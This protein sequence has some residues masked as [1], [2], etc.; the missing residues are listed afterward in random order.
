MRC[1]NILSCDQ[2]EKSSTQ[3]GWDTRLL[4]SLYS[5]VQ[6][7]SHA[8]ISLMSLLDIGSSAGLLYL[9]HYFMSFVCAH[10]KD[11]SC[12][13][14][15]IFS[16]KTLGWYLLEHKKVIY[17]TLRNDLHIQAQSVRTD[18]SIGKS[19]IIF[20]LSLTSSIEHSYQPS[21]Q[22]QVSESIEN[23]SA[24]SLCVCQLN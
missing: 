14:I 21:S 6:T 23:V 5:Q 9:F 10:C 18:M 11:I 15:F 13:S 17:F 20:F 24:A 19:F 8:F 2:H 16:Y 12:K 22:A 3:A 4:N 1:V 7:F